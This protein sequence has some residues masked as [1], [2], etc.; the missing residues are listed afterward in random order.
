MGFI[1][2]KEPT[3]ERMLQILEANIPAGRTLRIRNARGATMRVLE[4]TAWITEE[5][6]TEDYALATGDGRRVGTPGLTL[7]HAFHPVCL[8]VENPA[9]GRLEVML[10]G[11]YNEYAFAVFREQAW[12]MMRAAGRKM[13]AWSPRFR[14]PSATPTIPMPIPSRLASGLKRSTR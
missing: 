10:G 2:P 9:N 6:D 14:A 1:E 7:V 8:A 12:A 3:M 11:G 13:R 4:G 5:D